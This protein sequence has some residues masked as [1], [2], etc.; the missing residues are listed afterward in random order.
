MVDNRLILMFYLNDSSAIEQNTPKQPPSQTTEKS[1][2][3]AVSKK[4]EIEHK[5]IQN[6]EK[7]KIG[8]TKDNQSNEDVE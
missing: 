8:E 3:A 5:N 6:Q 1:N 4:E 2:A 7:N